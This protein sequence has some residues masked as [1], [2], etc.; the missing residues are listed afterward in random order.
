MS[1]KEM[2]SMSIIMRDSKL[3][4]GHTVP[5]LNSFINVILLSPLLFS[6]ACG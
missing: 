6:H 2:N 3:C 1:Q 4:V 5:I